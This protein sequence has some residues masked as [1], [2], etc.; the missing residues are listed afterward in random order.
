MLLVILLSK[1]VNL[2]GI[3]MIRDSML[4]PF[5]SDI[6][7]SYGIVAGRPTLTDNDLMKPLYVNNSWVNNIERFSIRH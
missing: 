2:L 4:C 6:D 3:E 7:Q 5:Y 1:K